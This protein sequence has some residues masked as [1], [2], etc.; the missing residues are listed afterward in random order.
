MRHSCFPRLAMVGLAG[1][2]LAAV[3]CTG[4]IRD[5]HPGATGSGAGTGTAGTG[6]A[7]GTGNGTGVAGTGSVTTGTAGTGMTGQVVGPAV[8]GGKT[9]EQVLAT[10]TAPSPGRTPMRRLSNAEY[11]NTINDLFSNIPAVQTLVST[12]TS[13]FPS[14]PESLG[15]RNSGD[16]LTVPQLAAQ[17]YLDAAE[18][19]AETA[20]AATNLVTCAGGVQDAKCA[21]T[22]INSF[23]KKV[24]R[25]PLVAED[26]ARY[27]ALYQKAITAGYDF[28]T[29]IEWIVFAML[30]SPQFLYRVELGSAPTNNVAKPTQYELATR[31]SYLYT[32]SMPDATLFTAADKGELATQAQIEAQARR[33]LADPKGQRLLDYFDQ[34]LGTDSMSE[35]VRD[36]KLF[37]NL[38][39][40][41]PSLLQGET[42]AFVSD[43]LKS[44]TGT[45]D[46][47]FTAPYTFANAALA[48]HYGLTGPTTSA[49][50]KVDAPGRAGV[51]TQGMMLTHDKAT[52]TSIVRRGLK[53]RTDVLCQIVPAPPPDVDLSSLDKT[54]TNVSQRQR[55][56]QHRTVASC[57]ACHTLMDPIGNVFEGFDAVGRARTVDET[58]MPVVLASTISATQDA[59][60][61]VANPSELGQKLAASDQV[62]GCYV[63]NNF[64]FFYGREVEQADACSM[65]RLLVDFKG[66]SYNLTELLV[67]LTRTDAF[68]YR[69]LNQ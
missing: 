43:L 68:L 21:T 51:L 53:I 50:Q 42:R 38:D 12:A 15:F 57:A 17:K 33:L 11:R 18:Q 31:L 28:K 14:E 34:W 5:S 1:L 61:A 54:A 26:T 62:R 60:G 46:Q 58:G 36:P 8:L 23:G 32:Q 37:P 22:F 25:R 6:S 52:R 13:G 55:L 40:T 30:Q 44:P 49:Y 27:D 3:A 69:G 35:M 66:G 59:N 56:E 20:A 7:T 48:K 24:Y 2:S 64:R 65:A 41:L 63:T 45:F 29:G 9:P 19:V 4:Q 47:L 10:C 16:Y 67:A 39:A